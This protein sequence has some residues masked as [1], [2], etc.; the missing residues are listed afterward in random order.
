MIKYIIVLVII[1]LFNLSSKNNKNKVYEINE[2][3]DLD[4][5]NLYKNSIWK[6][7]KLYEDILD[8]KIKVN[9]QNTNVNNYDP[10]SNLDYY[11]TPWNGIETISNDFLGKH[12]DKTKIIY[13]NENYNRNNNYNNYNDIY[14]NINDKNINDINYIYTM[15]QKRN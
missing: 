15:M 12:N 11:K 8:G 2:Y 4:N 7:T 10:N 5:Y 3:T 13:E 14:Q 1:L 6:N 9:Y